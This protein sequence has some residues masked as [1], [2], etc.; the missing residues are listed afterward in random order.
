[1]RPRSLDARACT[2]RGSVPT[3]RA[4]A[5]VSSDSTVDR[6]IKYDGNVRP[7]RCAIVARLS[8]SFVRFGSFELTRGEYAPS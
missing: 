7:E 8:R 5:L 6:D 1:M 4:A 3:T 2:A